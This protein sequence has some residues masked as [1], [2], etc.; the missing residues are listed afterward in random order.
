[1]SL[2]S[3]E[4]TAITETLASKSSAKP[5][6]TTALQATISVTL[7][8]FLGVVGIIDAMIVSSLLTPIKNDLH[9]ADEQFTRITAIT[10]FVG[11]WASPFFGFLG[12]RFGR[13]ATIFGGLT[14]LS[15]STIWSGFSAGYTA[16]LV[17]RV[18]VGFGAVSYN[19]LAPSW[20]ADLYAPKWRNFVFTM[21]HLKNRVGVSLA[22]IVGGWI[23]GHYNWHVAFFAT[24][25]ATFLLVILILLVREP[26]PGESD[27]HHDTVPHRPTFRE[28]L[29]VLK[30]KGYALHV[31]A[32]ALFMVGMYGQQWIPAYLYCTYHIPNQQP[33]V[34]WAPCCWP[35]FR[36][37]CSAA[38]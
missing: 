15:A 21:Y 24:G 23:A 34:F 13:K 16:L 7:I 9:L 27:G 6:R 17:S 32:Y 33:P 38:G 3:V 19:V 29:S 4:L 2:I 37:A 1:M 35:P 10:A 31:S 18:L 25:I 22:L 8:L 20:I 11:L 36:S 14:L 12:N 5:P 26:R 28:Q 30:Y